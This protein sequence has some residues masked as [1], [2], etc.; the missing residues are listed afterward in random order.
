[1]PRSDHMLW[2]KSFVLAA[3]A[4]ALTGSTGQLNHRYGYADTAFDAAPALPVGALAGHGAR[5]SQSSRAA[6]GVAT[7]S[8][9]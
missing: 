6:C 3:L 8:R 5:I 2:A 7:L 1:M 9:R 4:V